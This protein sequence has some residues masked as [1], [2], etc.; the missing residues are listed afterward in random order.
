MEAAAPPLT[1]W[2]P[3]KATGPPLRP[4]G[5]CAS[6][7]ARRPCGPPLT[8]ETSATPRPGRRGQ[9]RAL[10][11]PARGHQQVSHTTQDHHNGS[12]Y[13]SRGLPEGRAAGGAAVQ[14]G[15]NESG[16]LLHECGV[17]GPCLQEALGVAGRQVEL[18]DE[19][20]R[21]VVLV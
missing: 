20:D 8:P 18:V 17:V 14:L 16:L 9:A 13:G 2:Y 4:Q 3:R 21:A 12:L 7:C 1:C 11:R 10:P 5:C 6:R 19:H 15:G